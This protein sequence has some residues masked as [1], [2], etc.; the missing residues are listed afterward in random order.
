MF[1]P[2]FETSSQMSKRTKTPDLKSSTTLSKPSK[3]ATNVVDLEVQ[4]PRMEPIEAV[5]PLVKVASIPQQLATEAPSEFVLAESKVEEKNL[6]EVFRTNPT[7]SMFPWPHQAKLLEM[8]EANTRFVL[9]FV[10]SFTKARSPNDLVALTAAFSKEGTM[11]F[12]QQST[13]MLKI[14]LAS[15]SANP[16]TSS[17]TPQ[18]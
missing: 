6:K 1:E 15:L 13:R 8:A 5:D 2:E 12:Q 18:L 14:L 7:G 16:P 9:R 10:E 17:Q 3:K 4:P 11:L